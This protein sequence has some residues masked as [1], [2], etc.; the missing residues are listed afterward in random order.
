MMIDA[1]S[2]STRFQKWCAAAAILM[3][4]VPF[5]CV[6][7]YFFCVWEVADAL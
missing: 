5:A 2:H 4:L 7:T 1:S 6:Y 3:G